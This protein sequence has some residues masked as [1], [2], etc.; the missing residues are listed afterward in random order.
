MR[1]LG[2]AALAGMAASGCTDLHVYSFEGQRYDE[3]NQCLGPVSVIDVEQG[4]AQGTCTGVRCFEGE[5]GTEYVSPNCKAPPHYVDVTADRYD[6]KC[7]LA[8]RAY[9][10]GSNG[11]CPSG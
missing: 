8:M 5:D 10:L 2:I 3:V 7:R 4:Y 11:M 6:R 1:A 9:G